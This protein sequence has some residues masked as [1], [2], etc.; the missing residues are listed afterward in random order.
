MGHSHFHAVL[1]FYAWTTVLAVGCLLPLFVHWGWALV[2]IGI[3]LAAC[4][5][6]TLLPL[7]RRKAAETAAQSAPPELAEAAMFDPLDA[8]STGQIPLPTDLERLE[9]IRKKKEKEA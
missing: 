2:F 3:G 4:F 1:I 8:A 7:T 9:R 6:V 5:V